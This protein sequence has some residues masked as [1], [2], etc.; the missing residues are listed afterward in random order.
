MRGSLVGAVVAALVTAGCGVSSPDKNTKE[1][2][3][4]TV[5]PFGQSDHQYT[6]SRQGELEVTIT[7]V[8]PT[9]PNGQLLLGMGA[10]TNGV[11]FPFQG[12]ISTVVVNNPR[13]FGLVNKGPACLTIYDNGAIRAAT[14]YTGTI[15]YP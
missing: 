6:F 5:Q 1:N 4:G 12:Y 8:S 2:F 9:P 11:C 13:P 3:S 10:I 14:S 15:S 7:S